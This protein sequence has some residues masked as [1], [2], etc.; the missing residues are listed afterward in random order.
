[1]VP[2]G[3]P[4]RLRWGKGKLAPEAA[5][6][7]GNWA[8]AAAPESGAAQEDRAEVA[9]AGLEAPEDRAEVVTAGLEA[10]EDQVEAS[11]ARVGGAV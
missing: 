10:P 11:A 4:A 1:M 9:T 2:A 6:T 3:R 5:A 8:A 7:Q